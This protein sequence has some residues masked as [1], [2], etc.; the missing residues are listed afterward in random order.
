MMQPPSPTL[1]ISA[2]T[3]YVG[4]S[5][6]A[7]VDR[8]ARR[9][10][11]VERILTEVYA[12]IKG[13]TPIPWHTAWVHH[14]GYWSHFDHEYGASSWPLPATAR[15]DELGKFAE[16]RGVLSEQP[17]VGDLFLLWAPVKQEFVRSGIVL[18]PGD[19]G[20]SMRGTV[21][22]E[23]ETIEASTNREREECGGQILKQLR[24][25]SVEKGDRYVR[26]PELDVRAERMG[27]FVVRGCGGLTHEMREACGV[28]G[29]IG[30][31]AVEETGE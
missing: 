30:R 3:T 25:L 16:E 28:A 9:S 14:V 10:A 2:A 26:W 29:G 6:D 5:E 27:A 1:L 13:E 19:Y 8:F 22:Q 7:E 11:F 31:E 17:R 18:R 21:E 15:A 12:L 23:I 24:R 20:T 4:W